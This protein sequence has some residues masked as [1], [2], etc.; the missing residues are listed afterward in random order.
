MA[1]KKTVMLTGASGNMGFHGFQELWKK[2]DKFNIVVL[3]RNSE[4]NHKKFAEFMN[5]PA[6]RIVWGD[7]T[8]YEDVLDAVTGSDYVLHVGGMVSPAAD[9]KPYRTQKTNIGAAQNICKAV[10]A[11]PNAD[12]IKVAY[13]GTVAETGDRNYPIHW[14]RCGDPLKVSVYDHY[15]VSKVVAERVFVESGLKNWVVMRQSGILYPDILKNMDPI[16]FH[17]PLNGVLEWCTTEDSG[18]LIANL[19]DEDMKGNLDGGFWNHF[20][21]IGSGKEYRLT[22]YEIECLLLGTLGLAGPEKLFDPNWFITKNFHGQFYADSDKLENYLHFRENLPVKDYFN[23]LADGVE[24]YF[25]IPRYLPKGLVAACAK[26]FMK[27]MALTP[28]FGTLDWIKTNNDVRIS[29]YYGSMEEYK[30]LPTKW[31][32]MKLDHYDT[33]ISAA[34]E[35]KL[36]HGYDESKPESELTIEDMKQAAKFRGGECLSDTMVKGDMATKL[37]WKCGHCGAEFEASPALI[38]LGGHWCPECYV[39]QK[40]WDYDSIA[41]TNP[42]FAQVWY[43]NHRKDENNRYDFDT[44]FHINGVKWDDIKR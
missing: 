16:M 15:A 7:L 36:D 9:W 24:F 26:P 4:K 28:D 35:F 27:K 12:D 21:N 8:K 13:V 5:D 30:A 39:P 29:A 2:R 10:L 31:E 1:E 43:P 44:L 22:N 14:G 19:P 6:L 41:K 40:S 17:V 38:L 11:Q 32:D 37:K 34:D 23:R 18:R 25:K 42:F 20:F 33:D 3:L